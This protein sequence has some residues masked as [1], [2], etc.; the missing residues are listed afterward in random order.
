MRQ[1]LATFPGIQQIVDGSISFTAGITPSVASLT[2]APQNNFLAQVGP[3]VFF[4][5]FTTLV[6]P[7]ARIDS[8]SFE[9]NSKGMVWRLSIY[10]RRWKW[11]QTGG[12]G[13]ISLGANLR[14]HNNTIILA[15][16]QTP[17]QLAARCLNIL[18]ET[19]YDV[20]ALSNSDRPEISWDAALPAQVLEE[21][22]ES[23]GCRVVLGLDNRVRVCKVGSGD[24]LPAT[25][26][27]QQ[28][29]LSL[30]IPTM[31][32]RIIAMCAP[33][34]FQIDARL[35]AVG[36][37]NDGKGTLKPINFLS[38]MPA[39]GWESTDLGFDNVDGVKN[40]ELAR[41]SVFRYYRVVFPLTV[42][43]YTDTKGNVDATITYPWQLKVEDTQVEYVDED[44]NLPE[45]QRRLKPAQIGGIFFNENDGFR[46]N[47]VSMAD[48][49]P[50]QTDPLLVDNLA[51]QDPEATNRRWSFGQSR[52]GESEPYVIFDRPIFMNIDPTGFKWG[53]A[54]LILRTGC[55]L[56]DEFLFAPVRSFVG[57]DTGSKMG[58]R[59]RVDV[60]PDLRMWH[61]Y[62]YTKHA[63]VDNAD[64]IRKDANYYLNN[65]MSSYAAN[66]PQTVTYNGLKYIELDGA[67]QHLHFKIGPAG[68]STTASR[69]TEQ[70][71]R[72]QPIS[73]RKLMG[74]LKAALREAKQNRPKLRDIRQ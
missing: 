5:G 32:D 50:Y 64:S 65:I 53:A 24:Q 3:L 27:I 23:M 49:A 70:L 1:G 58:T 16:E 8:N 45:L 21:L 6:W 52:L 36:I 67:I 60:F 72:V 41:K 38:Y 62:D 39:R 2:I 11:Q 18:G 35:E 37:E 54:E 71:H 30:H 47:N 55:T 68:C 74:Q 57:R 9:R 46:G 61:Y 19:G 17:Q 28:D 51:I 12:G 7:D 33:D 22:C 31:P 20:S 63:V 43:G 14:N 10:D 44:R 4:D 73:Y 56:L 66:T 29:S 42:P 59:P 40:R 15:T 25:P 48:V 69:N 13:V 34:R 26:D